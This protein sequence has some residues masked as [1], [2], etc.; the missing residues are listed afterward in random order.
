MIGKFLRVYHTPSTEPKLLSMPMTKYS[1]VNIELTFSRC[2]YVD[3]CVGVHVCRHNKTKI[4]NLND[5]KLGTIVS[6][7]YCCCV[8]DV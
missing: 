2:V 4:P 7:V 6:E 8:C 3:M 5:S 1:G